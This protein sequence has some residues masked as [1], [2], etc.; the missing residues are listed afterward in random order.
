MLGGFANIANE[1]ATKRYRS[2]LINWGILPLRTEKDLKLPTDTWIFIRNIRQVIEEKQDTVKLQ[3]LSLPEEGGVEASGTL[4]CTLDNLTEDE[5]KILLAGSL[6]NY[7]K[8]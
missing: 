7:Y 3:I 1:Y 2:N 6:I 4:E 8:G 5:R